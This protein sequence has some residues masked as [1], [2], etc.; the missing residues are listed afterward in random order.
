MEALA[1][2]TSKELQLVYQ[3][4]VPIADVTS[5]IYCRWD[6]FYTDSPEL[7]SV[8]TEQEFEALREFHKVFLHICEVDSSDARIQDYIGTEYWLMY[9]DAANRALKAFSDVEIEEAFK[10][11]KKSLKVSVD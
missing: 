7:R 5:E 10:R 4:L 6:D 11:L 8:F 3:D 9:K 1:L 2:A